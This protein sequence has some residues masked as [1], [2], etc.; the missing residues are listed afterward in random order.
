MSRGIVRARAALFDALSNPGVFAAAVF[1]VSGMFMMG[2]LGAWRG[3]IEVNVLLPWGLALALLRLARARESGALRADACALFVLLAWLFAPF[4]IRFGATD[5]NLNCWAN[6][7]AVFFGVYALTAEADAARFDRE[8]RA[9]AAAFAA[10]CAVYAGALLYCAATAQEFMAP[11]D[12][13]GF[14]FGVYQQAQ[15]CASQHYNGTG[16]VALCGTLLCLCGAVRAKGRASRALHA[17]PA[18]M[19]ALVVVLTQSRTA[20]YSLLAGLAVGAYGWVAARPL[21][22]GR[23]V[24][25]AA[26]ALAGAIVLAGSYVAAAGITDAALAHYARVGAGRSIVL[27]TAV[28][29]EETPAQETTAQETPAQEETPAQARGAGEGTFTGRTAVWRNI[30]AMWRENPK[31]F[32]IGNGSGRTGRDILIGTPLEHGGANMAHNAYIQFT[33]DYGLIGFVLLAAFLLTLLRPALRVLLSAPGTAAAGCRPM[34]M[35]AVACLLTA[36]M[37]NE[38]L[39]AMRPCNVV[40]FFALGCLAHA[41]GRTPERLVTDAQDVV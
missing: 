19:M 33:M 3:F 25:H 16:M 35:L 20:R 7:T 15:L 28:A 31:Y 38:P 37:E 29:Q 10:I 27:A 11:P 9:A 17:V 22:G 6:H 18:L 23:I 24:R 41:G 40:F 32:L 13:N 14:G 1:A 8:L 26:G 34:A 21:H 2:E 12:G 39:N 36:M 4:A 5:A 30:F